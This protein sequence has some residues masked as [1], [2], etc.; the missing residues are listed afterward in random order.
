MYACYILA[1][2]KFTGIV[3]R[4]LLGFGTW[5]ETSSFLQALQVYGYSYQIDL[6]VLSPDSDKAFLKCC[7]MSQV[8]DEII[9]RSI[10]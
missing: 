6:N 8:V 3:Q 5:Q 1:L 10:P 9:E 2:A 4:V 7:Y